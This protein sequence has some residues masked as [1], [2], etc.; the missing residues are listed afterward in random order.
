MSIDVVVGEA[1]VPGAGDHLVGDLGRVDH[2][3]C[4]GDEPR[5]VNLPR[6]LGARAHSPGTTSDLLS[7]ICL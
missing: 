5:R 1:E 2:V 4:D 7:F 3:L 6:L